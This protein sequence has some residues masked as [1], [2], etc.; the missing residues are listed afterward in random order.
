MLRGCGECTYCITLTTVQMLSFQ[1]LS[2]RH[3]LYF[4]AKAAVGY[5]LHLCSMTPFIFGDEETIMSNLTKVVAGLSNIE[6]TRCPHIIIV[7]I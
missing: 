4:C 3:V 2:R 5:H 7:A 6:F 1:S